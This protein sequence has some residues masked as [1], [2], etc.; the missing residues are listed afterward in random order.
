MESFSKRI[1]NQL[2]E[3]EIRK[4]CCRYTDNAMLA[5]VA[6]KKED[7]GDELRMNFG[8]CRCDNCRVVYL[9]QLFNIFGSVTDPTKAYHLDL[10]F[11]NEGSCDAAE[12]ILAEIGFDFRRTIRRDNMH[13]RDKYVLYIK[14]SSAIEDF[15]VAVGA[16][17]AAFELMNSKIVNEFR[18]SVNRQVNCDTANIEKQLAAGK[19]YIEAIRYLIE[20]GRIETLSEELRE[21]AKLRYENEQLSLTEL[22]KLLNPPVSKSG[23]RHRLE[24]ILAIAEENKKQ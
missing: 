17:S 8:K 14:D 22:G 10:T 3:E 15:L 23:V 5:L 11:S 16:S 7:L 18:N 2:R 13:N 21:T 6:R 12:E 24:R 19:K 1:K 20:S 9:R 4:K